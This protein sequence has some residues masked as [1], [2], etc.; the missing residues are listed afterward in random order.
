MNRHQGPAQRQPRQVFPAPGQFIQPRGL[1]QD[2]F[3]ARALHARGADQILTDRRPRRAGPIAHQQR[4]LQFITLIPVV[5][6]RQAVALARVPGIVQM[7]P[8]MPHQPIRLPT[9][10]HR[11]ARRRDQR[12]GQRR[13]ADGGIAV[14]TPGRLRTRETAGGARQGVPPCGDPLADLQLLLHQLL[15][16]SLQTRCQRRQR[17]QTRRSLFWQRLS[18]SY[19]FT[20]KRNRLD[21]LAPSPRPANSIGARSDP[22]AQTCV[23][24]N[25]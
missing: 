23:D 20:R 9:G 4:R 8:V 3:A 12:L 7:R 16:A 2:R 10:G 15:I 11:S 14:K 24:T 22:C 19:G 21:K 1:G 18:E 13:Q 17:G 6:Q 5:A 25:G